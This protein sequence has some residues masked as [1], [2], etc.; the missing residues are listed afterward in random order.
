MNVQ[1]NSRR[2]LFWKESPKQSREYVGARPNHAFGQ[3]GEAE[4]LSGERT[5][6]HQW[7]QKS[8]FP[9]EDGPATTIN[10]AVRCV[11]G[12]RKAI[13]DSVEHYGQKATL[14]A[15]YDRGIATGKSWREIGAT[16]GQI[17]KSWERG[18]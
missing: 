9:C 11:A 17:V 14:Q 7:A 18:R 10:P 2:P 5:G 8:F 12:N 6:V 4:G 15:E 13:Y 1:N 16:L 3:T